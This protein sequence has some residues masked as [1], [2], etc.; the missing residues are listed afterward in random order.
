MIP[1]ISTVW[2]NGII[3]ETDLSNNRK[4]GPNSFGFTT[5]QDKRTPKYKFSDRNIDNLK[6]ISNWDNDKVI[7]SNCHCI[8][9]S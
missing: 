1:I 3:N 4:P 8:I 2:D 6:H 7:C 9:D 5:S